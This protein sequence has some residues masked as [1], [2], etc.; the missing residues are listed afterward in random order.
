MDQFTAPLQE[1]TESMHGLFGPF[2]E[3]DLLQQ[4][5]DGLLGFRNG[6]RIFLVHDET[7]T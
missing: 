2:V 6:Q 3:Q 5:E 4:I 1:F 7:D